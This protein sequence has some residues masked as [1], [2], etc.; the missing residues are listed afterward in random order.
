MA[1]KTG[2]EYAVHPRAGGEHVYWCSSVSFESAVHPRAGGE[3]RRQDGLGGSSPRGRGTLTLGPQ[4][5]DDDR[6]IPARA[7]NTLVATCWHETFFPF[8]DRSPI[9]FAG[10]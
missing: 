6:F 7:G 4:T 1:I 10:S 5:S 9:L 8:P 2:G 3:H